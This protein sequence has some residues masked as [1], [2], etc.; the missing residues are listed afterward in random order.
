MKLFIEGQPLP[1]DQRFTKIKLAIEEVATH[2]PIVWVA[3]FGSYFN[4]KPKPKDMD[5]VIVTDPTA[6]PH[7]IQKSIELAI[8]AVEHFVRPTSSVIRNFGEPVGLSNRSVD[9]EKMS[10][11]LAYLGHAIQD[12]RRRHTLYGQIPNWIRWYCQNLGG[13]EG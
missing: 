9:I 3:G 4:C 1:I 10:T 11:K 5:L 12:E 2:E 8:Q 13:M 7:K 6:D